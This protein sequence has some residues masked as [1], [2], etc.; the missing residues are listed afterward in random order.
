MISEI[1][2]T[3]DGELSDEAKA[4]LVAL[5]QKIGKQIEGEMTAFIRKAKEP[6]P[7]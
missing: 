5:D 1:L 6:L 2:K 3:R 7:L 4:N